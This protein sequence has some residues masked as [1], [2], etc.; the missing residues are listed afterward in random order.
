[1]SNQFN[2][3]FSKDQNLNCQNLNCGLYYSPG[4]D[5]F[6][7]GFDLCCDR[8]L[9]CCSNL[10]ND[11]IKL[12][13]MIDEIKNGNVKT[14]DILKEAD[15]KVAQYLNQ[16]FKSVKNLRSNSQN[17]NGVQNNENYYINLKDDNTL[18]KELDDSSNS[19]HLKKKNFSQK[20]NIKKRSKYSKRKNMNYRFL[21][22]NNKENQ[23]IID[24]Y[25]NKKISDT[26]ININSE[27]EEYFCPLFCS[28]TLLNS[29]YDFNNGSSCFNNIKIKKIIDNLKIKNR[30]LLQENQ[31]LKEKLLKSSN[32]TITDKNKD[33]SNIY[34][35]LIKKYKNLMLQNEKL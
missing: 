24:S 16:N 11:K 19:E 9:E 18:F 13:C 5:C 10:S 26:E 34:N 17:F 23:N 3:Y 30:F 12:N 33:N 20:N 2:N 8:N 21:N 31:N 7:S 4:Y 32:Y 27:N 1:M 6:Q 28:P 25:E 35:N 14:S 29:I 15:K 22:E